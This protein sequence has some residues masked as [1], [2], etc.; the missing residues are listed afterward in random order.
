MHNIEK[1]GNFFF[2]DDYYYGSV[3]VS[4][5][6]NYFVIVSEKNM[7]VEHAQSV[8]MYAVRLHVTSL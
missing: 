1:A 5:F 8:S 6:C 7:N 3:V 2:Y 4:P